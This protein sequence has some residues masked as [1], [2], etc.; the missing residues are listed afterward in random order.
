MMI[1]TVCII[2]WAILVTF[3]WGIVI[4][5]ASVIIHNENFTHNIAKIWAKSILFASR[6]RVTVTGYSNIDLGRSYIYMSNHQS[7]FDIPVLLAYL[8]TQFRWLAKAELFKIPIFG[9]SMKRAGYISINRS[10][11]RSAF[12]SLKE[13]A[14]KIRNGVSVLIFPEGT[15]SRDGN[16]RA[17]KKGGFV[18]AVDS[19]VP[20]VPI[21]IHGTWSIMSK[22]GIR[23]KPGNVVIEILK[24]IETSDYTRKTKDDL[25]G[26]VSQAIC[27]S[28]EKGRGK[29]R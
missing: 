19:G 8:D 20:V 23:I 13:A 2:V 17:F 7:N 21:V 22:K 3:F 16:I 5:L 15:R 10:N 18:L 9:S 12:E 26:K 27:R 24:P 6:I 4:I 11:R 25:M 29:Q 28:F 14:R 1:Q